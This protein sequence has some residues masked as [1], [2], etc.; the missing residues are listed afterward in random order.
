[1]CANDEDIHEVKVNKEMWT[2]QIG[3]LEA[4]KKYKIC[5]MSASY[6]GDLSEATQSLIGEVKSMGMQW[7]FTL[8]FVITGLLALGMVVYGAQA[9]SQLLTVSCAGRSS[10]RNDVNSTDN[11]PELVQMRPLIE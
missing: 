10:E 2:V 1:M 6:G 7:Y 8:L 11:P 5:M 9:I 3:N 4:G